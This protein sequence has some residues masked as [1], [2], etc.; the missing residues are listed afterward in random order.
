[1]KILH[2]MM[3]FPYPPD[4]G[5]RGD[6][7]SRVRALNRLGHSIDAIVMQQQ[8]GPRKPACRGDAPIR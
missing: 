4:A 7:W 5:C 3:E 6:T 8:A 2:V 1:M